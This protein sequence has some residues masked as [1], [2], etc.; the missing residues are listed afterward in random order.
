MV[1]RLLNLRDVMS[2]TS[3]SR[4]T[5]YRMMARAQ[6]PASI[7]LGGRVAWIDEEVEDWIA[8]RIAARMGAAA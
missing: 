8:A 6:F 1:T 4:T 2:R 7:A 3:L 5:I